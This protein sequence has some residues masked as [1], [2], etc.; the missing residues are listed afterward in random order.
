MSYDPDKLRD[1]VTALDLAFRRWGLLISV[2]K[3][4]TMTVHVRMPRE[5]PVEVSAMFRYNQRVGHAGK[6]KYMGQIIASD[7][8]VKG[9]V[10]RRLALAYAAF[11]KLGKQGIWIQEIDR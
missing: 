7:G 10:S 8:K 1:M 3:I 5:G 6:S 9:G 11:I 2:A 4:K